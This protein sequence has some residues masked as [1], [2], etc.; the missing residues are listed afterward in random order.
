[1]TDKEELTGTFR[2]R[3]DGYLY[4]TLPDG[5]SFSLCMTDEGLLIHDLSW[6][7]FYKGEGKTMTREQILALTHSDLSADKD[8]IRNVYRFMDVAGIP[9]N[10]ES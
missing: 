4:L 10:R 9:P 7:E 1:M 6:N 3:E 8:L 5:R 2:L